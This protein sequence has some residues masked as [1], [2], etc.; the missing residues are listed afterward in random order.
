MVDVTCRPPHSRSESL[1]APECEIDL[2]IP[3]LRLPQK[4]SIPQM[5]KPYWLKAVLPSQLRKVNQR[6]MTSAGFF[7]MKVPFITKLNKNTN[8]YI[9]C[10]TNLT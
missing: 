5:K 6:H 3:Y 7:L 10:F 1:D 4:L 9:T 8:L 2:S